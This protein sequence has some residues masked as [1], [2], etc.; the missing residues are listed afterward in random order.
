MKKILLGLFFA[1]FA[2][3]VNAALAPITGDL[4][5]S[6]GIVPWTLPTTSI[7]TLG[8]A[9]VDAASGDF[10]P[11]MGG[12]VTV[13]TA[14]DILLTTGVINAGTTVFSDFVTY[15]GGVASD[16]VFTLKE[17]V[18][19]SVNS[20]VFHAIITLTASMSGYADTD[21][22]FEFEGSNLSSGSFSAITPIATPIPA[23]VWLFGSA[24]MGLFGVSRR[25][26]TAVAA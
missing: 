3:Q 5:V 19:S 24:L 23:A 7:T 16:L 4:T 8:S 6:G 21:F 9:T 11:F 17:V 13:L 14:G 12:A 22:G 25:K 15:P 2:M 18:S 10:S 1:M 26:S 20:S